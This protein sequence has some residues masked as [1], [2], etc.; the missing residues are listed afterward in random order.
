MTDL[1]FGLSLRIPRSWY[2][3]DVERAT[4]TAEVSRLV[5]TRVA[6]EPALAP[7][8]SDLIKALREVAELALRQGAVFCAVMTDEQL[9]ATLMVFH[10]P[11]MPD[12]NTVE[13]IAAG[14][15][16]SPPQKDGPAWRA[17][18]IVELATG[19][20]VRV[21]GVDSH[22]FDSVV[23]HTLLPGPDGDG[24][25]DLVLASPHVGLTEPMLDLFDA[26]SATLAWSDIAN[27]PTRG[28]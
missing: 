8:R 12:G 1:P 11:G 20:A 23:M 2:E 21:T 13:T 15:V 19:P 4:R 7:H 6:A 17:V 28:E 5:D 14:V 25:V 10:T 9:L 3:F 24:V 18:R 22:D 16:A 27:Q 26:I